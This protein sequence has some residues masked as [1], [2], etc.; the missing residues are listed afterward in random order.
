MY[1]IYHILGIKIGCTKTINKRIKNQ[2][3]VEYVI[4]ETHTDIDIASKREIELQ[5]EYGYR[6][7]TRSYKETIPMGSINTLKKI[8]ASKKNGLK[9]KES[10]RLKDISKL[11]GLKQG[12]IQGQ[13]NKENGHMSNLGKVMVEFNNR[14]Q[15]CPYCGIE[16]RGI[17]YS[18][19]HGNNCNKKPSKKEG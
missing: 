15:I 8:E 9:I 18:R 10:G 17:G 6:V 2:G 13:K 19:W 7:E 14:N 5:Q 4:L 12:P 11:G 3:F 1:Y 16:S